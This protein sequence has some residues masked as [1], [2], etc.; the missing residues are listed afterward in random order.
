MLAKR[1]IGDQCKEVWVPANRQMVRNE[2]VPEGV[3]DKEGYKIPRD[4]NIQQIMASKQENLIQPIWQLSFCLFTAA[5]NKQE[6]SCQ[7][8][9]VS[10][11]DDTGLRKMKMK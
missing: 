4:F 6:E 11:P 2:H 9:G 5:V 8:V 7:I 1:S 10:I 3:L